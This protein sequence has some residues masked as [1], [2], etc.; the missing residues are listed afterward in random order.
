[1]NTFAPIKT[2]AQI[3]LLACV[4]STA[5]AKD[6]KLA[7]AMS[8]VES[9][10][11]RQGEV[12]SVFI[13]VH[14]NSPT[15]MVNMALPRVEGLR[16]Q[17]ST[18]T[19]AVALSTNELGIMK[20]KAV[21]SIRM[22]SGSLPVTLVDTA[23]SLLSAALVNVNAEDVEVLD[24]RSGTRVRARSLDYAASATARDVLALANESQKI[25]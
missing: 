10:L 3:V 16:A 23:G 24:E 19:N 6:R 13:L 7:D 4:F 12:E 25:I 17:T 15:S 21:V 2:A 20:P 9:A 14:E 18:E 5:Q 8:K 11:L 22:R 1:M